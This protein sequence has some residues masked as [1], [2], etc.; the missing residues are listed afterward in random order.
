MRLAQLFFLL[1]C[2]CSCVTNTHDDSGYGYARPVYIAPGVG[3][4]TIIAIV[5]SWTRNRSIL[6]AIIHGILGWLYVIYA[7]I[8]G[9]PKDKI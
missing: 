2:I 8:F 7:L 9:R 1:V 6:W 3:L 4:G 5:I